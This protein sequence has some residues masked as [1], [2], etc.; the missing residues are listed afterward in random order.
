MKKLIIVIFALFL[1]GCVKPKVKHPINP[2]NPIHAHYLLAQAAKSVYMIHTTVTLKPSEGQEGEGQTTSI[3]GNAFA[4]S[5]RRFLTA[6]HLAV[7]N[8][9]PVY[10]PMGSFTVFITPEEKLKEESW[11]V[12][13]DGHR[14]LAKVIYN[15]EDL[16]FAILETKDD[17][18]AP[19]YSIG[20]S[21]NFHLLDQIFMISDTWSGQYIKPG[22]IMQLNFVE[23]DKDLKI[24]DCNNDMFGIYLSCQEGNSGSPLFMVQDD[25]IK[26]VGLVSLG[27]LIDSGAGVK[28]NS[29]MDSFNN[30]QNEKE[31]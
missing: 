1:I 27:N 14:T 28:I 16:D 25:Q 5:K 2:I 19:A 9:Y 15:D 17:M 8:S 20:N 12:L 6:N 23:K 22:Y 18:S 29:I 11:L 3:I 4:I 26:V 10:T 13:D 24:T 31:L 21:D 7:I 30:W